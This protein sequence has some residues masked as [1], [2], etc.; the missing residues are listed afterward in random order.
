MLMRFASHVEGVHS[1]SSSFLFLSQSEN[2]LSLWTAG[3]AW[4]AE[5]LDAND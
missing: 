1:I 3:P 4:K 2:F 5:K